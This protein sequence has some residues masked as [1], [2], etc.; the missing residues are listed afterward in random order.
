MPDG[1]F[2]ERM[3]QGITFVVV[4]VVVF[5]FCFFSRSDTSV[6]LRIKEMESVLS[7]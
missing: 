4:V 5:V 3:R 6:F 7:I 1:I 2:H